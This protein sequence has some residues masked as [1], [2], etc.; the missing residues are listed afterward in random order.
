[1]VSMIKP[2]FY[3]LIL[4]FFLPAIAFS[5]EDFL[6]ESESFE[7]ISWFENWKEATTKMKKENK[8]VL[9]FFTGSDWC[10]WCKKMK[11]E[12][13]EDPE[14]IQEMD[15]LLVFF[16]VDFPAKKSQSSEI[17]NHNESLKVTYNIS[18]LPTVVLLDSKRTLI[19]KLGYLP[20]GG[21]KYAEYLK[22]VMA[23]YEWIKAT[24]SAECSED[25]LR[26]LYQKAKSMGC[27]TYT[28]IIFE[29][30]VKEDK[31]PFFLLEKYCS[32]V[33]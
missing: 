10:P 12:I 29:R 15:P 30:G 19:S 7:N 14:F 8:L 18:G 31:V 5:S 20:V 6:E 4:T 25:D 24:L 3:L 28:K 21:G 22:N 13:F 32:L 1:M 17:I 33:D 2:R 27:D 16:I 23:D 11:T 9:L 26:R